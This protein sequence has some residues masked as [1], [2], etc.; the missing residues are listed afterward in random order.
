MV[1]RDFLSIFKTFTKCKILSKQNEMKVSK[2]RSSELVS[3]FSQADALFK[4]D[5][6]ERLGAATIAPLTTH[7]WQLILHYWPP[8][9]LSL[10]ETKHNILDNRTPGKIFSCLDRNLILV[11]M[12]QELKGARGGCDIAQR[13]CSHFSPNSPGF[14]SLF[15]S[16]QLSS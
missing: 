4:L 15:F 12:M 2:H 13:W 9:H 1:K 8:V 14:E 7:L 5:S 10:K 3:K 6:M 11:K 16:I